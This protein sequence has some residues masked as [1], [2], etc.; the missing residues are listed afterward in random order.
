MDEWSMTQTESCVIT[1]PTG[2]GSFLN[3]QAIKE[4]IPRIF[5]YQLL[6]E[7][8]W[9][10]SW[11]RWKLRL[12][13]SKPYHRT[14]SY[15]LSWPG[16]PGWMGRVPRREGRGDPLSAD[17]QQQLC[18]SYG[19]GGWGQRR[20]RCQHQDLPAEGC[21]ARRAGPQ[22]GHAK[23]PLRPAQVTP[24][25]VDDE[26][27]EMLPRGW[28][29]CTCAGLL[30]EH[31]TFECSS[32]FN[33]GCRACLSV[34]VVLVRV[35][36]AYSGLFRFILAYSGLFLRTFHIN[37]CYWKHQLVL[38]YRPYAN[39][40]WPSPELGCNFNNVIKDTDVV[41]GPVITHADSPSIVYAKLHT[42]A[43]GNVLHAH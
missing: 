35:A 22:I 41:I 4:W 5:L 13:A 28:G 38:L 31:E 34:F 21:T 17:A 25:T 11:P 27:W 23:T 43:S 2:S 9:S 18:Q 3:N 10:L 39:V 24:A 36:L 8:C 19:G 16:T 37:W 7:K 6:S 29:W 15:S 20:L 42:F 26:W 40:L 30:V 14:K 33:A 12:P 1:G 32:M